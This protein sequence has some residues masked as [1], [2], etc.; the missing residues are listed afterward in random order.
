VR[1]EDAIKGG[2]ISLQLEWPSLMKPV[3]PENEMIIELGRRGEEKIP[4]A[5]GKKG[6]E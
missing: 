5:W 3:T 6:K 2:S 1:E 4:N